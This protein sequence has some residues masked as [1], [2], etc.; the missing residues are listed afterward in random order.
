MTISAKFGADFA[1]F[2]DAAAQASVKLADFEGNANKVSTSL[3][4]VANS[5]SGTAVVQ[6]A[7]IAAEAVD[8]IGGIAALTSAEVLRIGA[9]AI[10]AQ[11]KLE[12]LGQAVPPKIQ[13][14]ADAARAL[15]PPL[16][17]AKLGATELKD[18][19]LLAFDH[20]IYAVRDLAKAVGVDLT[21][22]FGA[23][24]VT[25][26]VSGAAIVGAIALIGKESIDVALEAAH[27]GESIYDASLKMSAS[28]PAVSN[29]KFAADAAGGSLDQM[30]ALAFVMQ[31]R[32][33]QNP[34]K[35][36]DG[37]KA[38][39][40]DAAA[41]RALDVDQ[42]LIA[43]STGMRQ[44]SEE[45]NKQAVSME[46]FGR[47]GRD[48]LTILLK[49]LED[50]IAKGRELGFTWGTDTAVS[51]DKLAES[52]RILDAEWTKLKT[53]LGVQLI[54][55]I[56]FLID[57]LGDLEKAGIRVAQSV[58][59]L[60]SLSTAWGTLKTE[61]EY[62]G[63]AYD[64]LIGKVDETPAATGDA[65]KGVGALKGEIKDMA[66]YV[67]T[68]TDALAAQREVEK[69]LD[70]ATRKLVEAYT[71]MA[72]AGLGWRGTLEGLDGAVVEAVRFYLE[73]GVAQ[74]KLAEAYGLTEAQV[75][76]VSAALKDETESTKL[77]AQ[78][79][80]TLAQLEAQADEAL[81]K[82]R[83]EGLVLAE[84]AQQQHDAILLAED[85]NRVALGLG[86]EATYQ[87]DKAR[88]EFD[89][90]Q[91]HLTLLRQAEADDLASNGVRLDAELAKAD[92]RYAKGLVTKD[93]Y[94]A[95]YAAIEAKYDAQR[96][97]IQ[98]AYRAHTEEAE[99]QMRATLQ[100]AQDLLVAGWGTFGAAAGAALDKTKQ[101]IDDTTAAAARMSAALKFS[102]DVTYQNFLD[103][104]HS[105]I[106]GYG[107]G[108]QGYTT[109]EHG[110]AGGYDS[111]AIAL[112]KAG[113][114]FDQ[115]LYILQHPNDPKPPN[116]G[117]RIPGYEEGGP[118][119][120]GGIAV[121]HPDEFVVPKGGALVAG[122][123]RGGDTYI[124]VQTLLG[125]VDE[126][127]AAIGQ[128][129]LQQSGRLLVRTA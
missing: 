60:S 1:S 5:L 70:P 85:R 97:G 2:Q 58:P 40:V 26:V 12:A 107:L 39:N 79:D 96:E 80:L 88:I 124:T 77:A 59:F 122:G 129:Q 114:S 10:E 17:D 120:P 93:Q 51:A 95:Q 71:E 89:G 35:F 3:E 106:T 16:D 48:G 43:I 76:A 90:Y 54:P 121:L 115:V 34:T 68:V 18:A 102:Y 91:R 104:L 38:I 24:E 55:T 6:Q 52:S 69:D 72:S 66:L 83:K 56:Q 75:K 33:E 86:T 28:V 62:A 30:A 32:M 4:R 94:E 109:P 125:T 98:A 64:V 74:N 108:A 84:A 13:A 7:T 61:A 117:P 47:Q 67:P 82:Q 65:A 9:N 110:L 127:A 78:A 23:A 100:K 112:A 57:H 36:D 8:R 113:Y 111:D 81:L 15:K 27:L 92:E 19:I 118:T 29:L 126:L 37:L 103:S 63:L 128:A 31:Q 25:A 46:L 105:S 41:F 21:T 123:A 14:I 87:A 42:K 119:G 20:P 22:A 44:A 99:G 116:P 49:P 53:D 50:L 73:A 11:A 101:K 45:T